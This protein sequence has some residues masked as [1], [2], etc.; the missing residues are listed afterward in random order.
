MPR[1]R[2]PDA[3]PTARSGRGEALDELRCR[4]PQTALDLVF[5]AVRRSEDDA[6]LA[7]IAAGPLEDLI[8]DHGDRF[9]DRIDLEASQEPRFRRAL[10]GVWGHD[11][12]SPDVAE[13]LA[14]LVVNEPPL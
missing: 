9:I 4:D 13:R 10:R 14:R 11:R 1:R 8:V 7:Y 12:M 5:E 2:S 3:P 6:T